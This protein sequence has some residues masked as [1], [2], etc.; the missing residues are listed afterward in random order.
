[1]PSFPHFNAQ[2]SVGRDPRISGPS[3]EA[4]LVSGLAA[5]GA[6]VGTFGIATTPCMFYSIVEGSGEWVCVER[7]GKVWKGG[8]VLTHPGRTWCTH[9]AVTLTMLIASHI[10][11]NNPHLPQ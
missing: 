6:Q 2:V 4:S 11:P 10:S 1:M 3:L 8:P 5:A 7:C 9:G